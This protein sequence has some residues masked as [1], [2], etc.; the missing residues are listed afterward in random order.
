MMLV[1]ASP[2]IAA[3]F[4]RHRTAAPA[5]IAVRANQHCARLVETVGREPLTVA[6][7]QLA[8]ARC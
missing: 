8:V 6:I 3:G 4:S 2:S 5:D 1:I 7:G